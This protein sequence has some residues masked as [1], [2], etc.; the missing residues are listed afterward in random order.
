MEEMPILRDLTVIIAVGMAVAVAL[1]LLRLPTAAGLLAAGALMGPGGFG[2]VESIESIHTLAEIGVI[3]LLFSIGLE[4]SLDRLARIAGLV[5]VGGA[6]QVGLTVAATMGIALG[7]GYSTEKAVL[8]GFIVSLSST[9]IVLRSLNERGEIDA[10]HGRFIV[11]ALLFQDLAVVPMMLVIPLLGGDAG[12]EGSAAVPI[13]IALGK[14]A[15][16]VV[17]TMLVAR[18]IVPV[19]FQWVDRAR[20]REVFLLAVLSICIATAW[21][22]SMAGLSLA[23]GAFLG[24]IVVA[25]TVYGSRALGDILP[26]R[27][28]FMSVFFVSLGMLFDPAAVVEHPLVITLLVIGFVLGKA[29]LAAFAALAMRFPARVAFLSGL[30]LGQFSEFGFVLVNVAAGAGVVTITETR[31]ILAAGIL[32]MFL[33]PVVVMLSPRLA[34]G[35]RLLRPLERLIGVRG[36]DEC[37]PQHEH[38]TG[39]V[40]V[41]G[42]G[43]AGRLLSDA[44][45]AVEVPYL[46]LELNADAVRKATADGQPIYYG[47]VTNEEALLHARAAEARAAV[48]LINDRE[49]AER[50]VDTLRRVA[51][52][53]PILLRTRYLSTGPA[54][55]ARGAS[56]IVFE[57]VEAGVEMLGRVLRK[58]DVPLNLLV[59]QL[60]RARTATQASPRTPWVPRKRLG[61]VSDLDDL[62]IEKVLVRDGDHGA[63]RTALDLDLRRAAGAL[64]VAIRRNGALIA[65]PDPREPFC[66]GDAVYLVGS[67]QQISAA[68]QL[69]TRGGADPL[70]SEVGP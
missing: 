2:L 46:I 19:L 13:L 30:G 48:I 21:L 12:K 65:N 68:S 11:G 28:V 50:A 9:A 43:V 17:A 57:E 42:Y 16:V 33:T 25:G 60:E 37:A 54:L 38:I 67:R 36:I 1:S 8:F 26:L 47:D 10:P 51:P 53:V 58:F 3:L 41:V 32:S 4:F 44:L 24:G 39:H 52:A 31:E 14:A 15:V 56:D 18:R 49:A 45:A 20:S 6:L 55:V 5:A 23:L 62:K 34:A 7:L 22:T 27:D 66:A 29:L 70:A 69:L 61:E 63:G 64:A 40:L 59:E 35:A